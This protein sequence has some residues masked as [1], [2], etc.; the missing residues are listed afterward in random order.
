[1]TSSSWGP[2]PTTA[3]IPMERA[4]IETCEVFDPS[5]VTNPRAIPF[6]MRAVSDGAR[7][8]ASTTE[9]VSSVS[10]AEAPRPISRAE[11]WRV[12]SRTSSALAARYSSSIAAYSCGVLF[13]DGQHCRFGA[14]QVPYALLDFG[15][16]FGVLGHLDVEVED[17]GFLFAPRSTEPVDRSPRCCPRPSRQPL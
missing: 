15:G 14:L 5:A 17:A 1:M 11:I 2:T 8:R 16:E 6:W 10:K 3:G 7:L 4:M 13:T 12:T 9:G